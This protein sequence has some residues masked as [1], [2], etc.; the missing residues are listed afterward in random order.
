MSKIEPITV[1]AADRDELERL[2]R[3]RNTAQKVVWRARIVLLAAE[4]LQ[5]G[6]IAAATG[7]SQRPPSSITSISTMPSPKPFVWTKSAGEIL[8]KIARAKQALESQALAG[9]WLPQLRHVAVISC[10]WIAG[11]RLAALGIECNFLQQCPNSHHSVPQQCGPPK[12]NGSLRRKRPSR[13]SY[14]DGA[15]DRRFRRADSSHPAR[16]YSHASTDHRP[17]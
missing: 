5:A 16:P 14:S 1:T 9:G 8:E 15:R 3:D 11:F 2:V 6:A 12:V 4:G 7:K 10:Q 17:R 13:P